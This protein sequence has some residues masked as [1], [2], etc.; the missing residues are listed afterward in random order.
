MELVEV[1]PNLALDMDLSNFG[2]SYVEEGVMTTS[3]DRSDESAL[4]DDRL[5]VLRF[6]G[7]GNGRLSELLTISNKITSKAAYVGHDLESVDLELEFVG[8]ESGRYFAL[9]QNKP[10]PWSE[11]TSIGFHLPREQSATLTVYD[12]NGRIVKVVKGDF[13]RGNNIISLSRQDIRGHGLLYYRLETTDHTA[14]R[15]MILVD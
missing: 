15:K 4:D 7:K 9:Y 3:W 1:I 5:F 14:T 11:T 2:M 13:V 10:N 8:G 6:K 12:E